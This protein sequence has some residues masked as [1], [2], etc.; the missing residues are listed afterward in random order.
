MRVIHGVWARGALCLWGEDPGLPEVQGT[1][2][3]GQ[4]PAPV[5]HPFACQAAELA[6]LLAGLPG[7]GGEAAR[8]AVGDE[9]TLQLPSRSGPARPLASPE[10][11]RPTATGSATAS[12]TGSAAGG[13]VRL[14]GWRV[15]VLVFAPP[16]G[17]DLLGAAGGLGE[18]A[19]AGASLPYLAALAR[20]ADGLAARGR[21]LPV[22][23]AEDGGYAARWRPVLG[24]EDEQ[25][26]R[27]LAAAMPPQVRAA[28]GEPARGEPG[29]GGP[30]GGESPGSLLADALDRLT[31]AA[32][33][34]RLPG[35]VL[36]ARRGRTPA[37]IPLAERY[38]VSLTSTD[39]R[40]DVVTPQDEA[41]AAELAAELDAWLDRAQIPAGPVRTCFR[42][43]EPS[44]GEDSADGSPEP[45]RQDADPWQVEFALQSTED[46]SLMVPAADVWAGRGFGSGGDP[47]EELLAGLGAA[48]RLFGGLEDA[49][50]EPAPVLVEMDTPG[51]FRF[52]KE[53]APL[54]AGA[55]FGVLLPDWVRKA[56][57]GLK[58]TTRSRWWTSATTWQSATRRSTRPSW[59]NSPGSRSP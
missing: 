39:A 21:V 17:L 46:P 42:L 34:A 29:S 27:D 54:L 19:T 41:E 11:I 2:P 38:V 18:L 50:R 55:G 16:L 31:D 9:L 47:A 20:F 23:A 25:R 1:G 3:R 56:R 36:P 22:L 15:P 6:D 57:L 40:L 24:G 44:G 4:V 30:A 43:V 37:R 53:T 28:S 7:P 49:L 13:R 8:K 32:A 52:L 48:A 58:L 14:A 45:A 12:A 10:L 5:P 33:R 26:A 35:P 51:A 59:P